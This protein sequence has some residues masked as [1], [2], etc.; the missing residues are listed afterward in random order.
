M[1]VYD[2]ILQGAEATE[3]NAINFAMGFDF[4]QVDCQKH[5]FDYQHHTFIDEVNGINVYYNSTADYYFF[6][7]V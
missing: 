1:Q 3:K 2:T 7:N 4:S 6:T 5:K